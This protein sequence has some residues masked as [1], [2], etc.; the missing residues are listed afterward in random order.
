MGTLEIFELEAEVEEEGQAVTIVGIVVETGTS[1]FEIVLSSEMN[2]AG[3]ENE[4]G[5]TGIG[6]ETISEPGD[7]LRAEGLLKEETFAMQETL[8]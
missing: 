2:V 3:S 7:L 6:I 8:L 5:E 4:I 1:I